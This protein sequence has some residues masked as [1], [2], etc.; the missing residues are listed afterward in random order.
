MNRPFLVLF[1][2]LACACGDD[3]ASTTDAGPG[4]DAAMVDF[5]AEEDGF[6]P[7]SD[8]G[9]VDAFVIPP[10]ELVLEPMDPPIAVA[11]GTIFGTV[12]YGP[13]AAQL[14]D[15]FI[16]PDADAPTPVVIFIHGGG[17]T[18]GSRNAAYGGARTTQLQAMPKASFSGTQSSC[19]PPLND[20]S[21]MPASAMDTQARSATRPKSP[22]RS[23]SDPMSPA[24]A[25]S[26][27]STMAPSEL[28]DAVAGSTGGGTAAGG[29]ALDSR[30]PCPSDGLDSGPGGA[31]LPPRESAVSAFPPLGVLAAGPVEGSPPSPGSAGCEER[32][33]GA[34]SSGV[35]RVDTRRASPSFPR[36]NHPHTHVRWVRRAAKLL[37]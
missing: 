13:G 4:L 27:S 15:V 1:L 32:V 31:G 36:A 18:G 19:M 12:E 35:T 9:P 14:M 25:R 7:A 28:L 34:G 3:D 22:R 6:T 20:A 37:P 16:H 2:L 17:F 11:A 33:G 23:S 10:D 5:G 26:R 24:G 30:Y 21:A 8:L 29:R